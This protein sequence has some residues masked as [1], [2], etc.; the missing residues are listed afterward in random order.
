MSRKDR[1]PRAP[2][3]FIESSAHVDEEVNG[4]G[5]G[6]R[7][8]RLQEVLRQEVQSILEDA[9]DPALWRIRILAVTLS[10]DGSHARCAYAVMGSGEDE[11]RVRSQ[12]AETLK[13]ATPFVRAKVASALS[14]K[15]LPNLSF[16][17][18]GLAESEGGEA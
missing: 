2:K 16:T 4:S 10:V 18:V 13:R 12:S 3:A 15:R 5:G 6:H 1:R 9:A 17:F 14:I 11:G 8:E 7:R